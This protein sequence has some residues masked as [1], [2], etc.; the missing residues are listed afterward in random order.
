LSVT[1]AKVENVEV[2]VIFC[3]IYSLGRNPK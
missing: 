1:S 2:L 3:T